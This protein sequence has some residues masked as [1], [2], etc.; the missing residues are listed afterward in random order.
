MLKWYKDRGVTNGPVFQK[1][2][3]KRGKAKD[4]KLE[5]F[6][7]L[8]RIQKEQPN[9]LDPSVDIMEEFGM[10]R[11]FRRGSDSRAI[12]QEIGITTINLNNRWRKVEAAK[13]KAASFQ[14]FEHYA[15]ITLLLGAF[16]KFSSS[17]SRSPGE[18]GRLRKGFW[19]PSG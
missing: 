18:S 15:D 5:I 9:V 10:S 16:L 1:K 4:Y 13:G 19:V 11:S 2:N 8:E 17:M 6:E 12:D 7:R 14:M 3:G